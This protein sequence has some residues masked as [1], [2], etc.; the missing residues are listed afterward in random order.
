MYSFDSR[1]GFSMVDADKKITVNSIVDYFQDASTFHS[2]D[3]GVGYDYLLPRGICW[4]INTWQIDIIKY[5]KY[6]DR[7]KIYTLPYKFRGFIGYRNFW[8]ENVAGDILVK[9]NSM[10]SLIDLNNMKPAKVP[11]DLPGVYGSAEPIDMDYEN[12][13]IRVPESAESKGSIMVEGHFLDPNKHMNNGQYVN[14]ASSYLPDGFEI[15]RLRAEYRN[16][17]FLGDR[18]NPVFGFADGKYVAS[19]NNDEGKPY[20]VIEFS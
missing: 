3:L 16:Q 14:I 20:S 19:L 12:G 17:A 4:V 2:E 8:I 9:A 5:P 11:D 18:I 1:V 15:K 10:W 6:L 7:V 13:K